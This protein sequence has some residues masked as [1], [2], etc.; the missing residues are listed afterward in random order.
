AEVEIIR[1]GG[2]DEL[3]LI[4]AKQPQ[5]VIQQ[6]RD[7]AAAAV[8]GDP[9]APGIVQRAGRFDDRG[10]GDP[11]QAGTFGLELVG[12]Q[13]DVGARSV[14]SGLGAAG[15]WRGRLRPPRFRQRRAQFVPAGIADR[16]GEPREGGRIGAGGRREIAHRPRGGVV[17]VGGD[18]TPDLLQA[19]GKRWQRNAQ[20]AERRG[21]GGL[22]HE[23]FLSNEDF[24][25]VTTSDAPRPPPRHRFVGHW[26]PREWQGLVWQIVVVGIAVG[27]IAFLWSNT[28]TNLSA[29][30]ITTGFAFLG[31]EAG[32]PI[33]DSLLA[34]NPRDSYLWAFV[35]G[36]ANTLRVA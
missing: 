23:T 2:A 8:S 22:D 26:G 34:Y 29:R 7:A 25:A 15:E 12:H 27:V 19:H 1:P 4:G 10:G 5:L 18:E 30:R 16:L 31:R 13:R 36:I 11:G 32:M 9:D 3:N 20:F 21:F 14:A 6:L 17:I 33:A 28:V 24:C 35:V